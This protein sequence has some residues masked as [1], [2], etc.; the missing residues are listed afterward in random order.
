[1]KDYIY[2]LKE[3]SGELARIKSAGISAVIFLKPDATD[4]D[5]DLALP[6]AILTNADSPEMVLALMKNLEKAEETE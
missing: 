5:N 1:M 6:N 2:A 3:I 4:V